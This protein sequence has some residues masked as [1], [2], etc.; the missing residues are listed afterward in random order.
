MG[1]G[2]RVS[3]RGCYLKV[4]G[5]SN[6]GLGVTLKGTLEVYN[7]VPFSGLVLRVLLTGSWDLVTGVRSYPDYTPSPDT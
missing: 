6:Y 3:I 1:L 5:L 4:H 2:F 7:R